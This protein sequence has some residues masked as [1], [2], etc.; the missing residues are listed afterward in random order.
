MNRRV[1]IATTGRAAG[2]SLAVLLFAAAA[3]EGRAQEGP[4]PTE[5]TASSQTPETVIEKWPE[6]ARLTAGL[7]IAKYG[8]PTRWSEGALVWIAN[9]PWEKSVVY[10]S[11]W[12]H[13]V[14]Q[15]DKD[16]LEQTTA[17][18]VP[19]AKIEDL[20][21]FNR[22]LE[23]DTKHGSLSIRSES[24]PMNFLALNLADEIVAGKRSVEEAREVYLKVERLS[25]SGKS[26][27]YT[28]GLLFPSPVQSDKRTDQR[29]DA[30]YDLNNMP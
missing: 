24:E 6:G 13:Y 15:R 23:A 21:R 2:L 16:Y 4:P 25:K 26:S 7:M 22:L 20:K 5:G 1:R 10:R 19:S 9:G 8:E 28:E 17:Y 12:P 3:R 27:A 14:G 18:R 11:A 29:F 30:E